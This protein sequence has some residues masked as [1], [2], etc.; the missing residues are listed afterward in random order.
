MDF[1][2]RETLALGA[3]AALMTVLP[4]RVNAASVDDLTASFTGGADMADTGITLNA[5]EIAENGNTVPISVSAPGATAIM[6]LAAGNP[7]PPVATFNFGPLAA[8]QS[9]S[10]RIR[11]AGTQDVVAIAQL[12]DG[13]FARAA[14]T[15]KVTIGG[16]G[17]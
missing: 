6:V 4:F 2:R 11:L 5:P 9:A 7:T 17:G 1:T 13:S 8:E 12:A 14:S 15:V 3:G 10:T 16:C